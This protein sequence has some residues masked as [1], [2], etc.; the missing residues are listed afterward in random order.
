MDEDL[1]RL[2]EERQKNAE[3][4][5]HVETNAMLRFSFSDIDRRLRSLEERV[6]RLESSRKQQ[7]P[8]SA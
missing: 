4:P 5:D 8:R 1:K 3:I 6:E 2:I 7:P